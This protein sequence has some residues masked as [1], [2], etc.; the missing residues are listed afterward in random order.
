MPGLPMAL[1]SNKDVVIV[2]VDVPNR[3]VLRYHEEIDTQVVNLSIQSSEVVQVVV[4]EV[5]QV[6]VLEAL[7][8]V[9]E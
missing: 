8:V 4:S 6:G 1:T 5:V 2:T 3:T 9:A 7:L